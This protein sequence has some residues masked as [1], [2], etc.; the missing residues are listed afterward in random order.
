M[1][2]LIFSLLRTSSYLDRK[3]PADSPPPRLPPK[4][5]ALRE[6]KSLYLHTFP[7]AGGVQG[8]QR[9]VVCHGAVGHQ[10]QSGPFLSRRGPHP[11]GAASL[12]TP[13]PARLDRKFLK[14]GTKWPNVTLLGVVLGVLPPDFGQKTPTG[15][16]LGSFACLRGTSRVQPC[17]VGPTPG[18]PTT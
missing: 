4:P 1:E 7:C 17:K 2:V 11:W 18:L 10:P 9:A 12:Q 13:L 16:A 14:K 8:G 15:P 6:F 3:N 5:L